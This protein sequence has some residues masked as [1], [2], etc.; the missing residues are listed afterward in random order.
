MVIWQSLIVS[1]LI[2][3]MIIGCSDPANYSSENTKKVVQEN[4]VNQ[5]LTEVQDNQ[6]AE[7][8]LIEANSLLDAHRYQE[9]LVF[10]NRIIAIK[11]DSAETWVN[12]GN[13][14]IALQQYPEAV[15]SYDQA[16]AI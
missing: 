12:R 3:L 13:A 5:L 10:Y 6:K 4:N 2:S 1:S 7:T 15:K 8:L 9:A 16:I 11:N 14:L